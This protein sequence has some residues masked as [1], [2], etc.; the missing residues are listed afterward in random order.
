MLLGFILLLSVTY[1]P[2][3]A[4]DEKSSSEPIAIVSSD[5]TT[6]NLLRTQMDPEKLEKYE[7]FLQIHEELD[8]M[9]V[10]DTFSVYQDDG[11]ILIGEVVEDTVEEYP[12]TRAAVSKTAKK[13]ITYQDSFL[14][15]KTDAFK[16]SLTCTWTANGKSSYIN[17]L[18]GTATNYKTSKYSLVWDTASF[19][20]GKVNHI[21][22][23]DVYKGLSSIS[24]GYSAWCNQTASPSISWDVIK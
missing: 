16:V 5:T 11:S 19:Q 23:L 4:S 9:E 20:S 17:K 10:G 12:L 14:G 21:M 13:T 7:E 15:I 8:E 6:I 2:S 18:Q 1:I 3:Y 24:Y 22:W